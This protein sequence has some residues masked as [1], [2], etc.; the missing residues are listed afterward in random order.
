MGSFM[1]F[2]STF[3]S[4][5]L[6]ISAYVILGLFVIFALAMAI[7][8]ALPMS[9]SCT[10]D[11]DCRGNDNKCES[12]QTCTKKKHLYWLIGVAVGSL[13]V[14][15]GAYWLIKRASH[16]KTLSTVAAFGAEAN[17]LGRAARPFG[18][19]SKGKKA[20]RRK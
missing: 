3:G 6:K 13:V 20:G 7:L 17:F 9:E 5:Y 2:Q 11:S 12:A 15:Y 16:S 10:D 19:K 1:D 14:G 4:A 8:A 18:F